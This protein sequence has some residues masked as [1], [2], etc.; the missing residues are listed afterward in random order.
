MTKE[1]KREVD[2]C[3][4]TGCPFCSGVGSVKRI[5]HGTSPVG[6]S[7]LDYC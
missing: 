3:A 6:P 4:S 7:G 2:F 1:M 5:C